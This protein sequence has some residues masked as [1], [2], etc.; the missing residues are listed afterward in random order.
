M[1][2]KIFLHLIFLSLCGFQLT[3]QEVNDSTQHVVEEKRFI[4][5]PDH[6]IYSDLR[7]G[8]TNLGH[9][10]HT[11]I[12]YKYRYNIFKIGYSH[13]N[14]FHQNKDDEN[15]I[16]DLSFLYGWSF[17]KKNFL[18]SASFGIGGIWGN[19]QT[20]KRDLDTIPID[21]NPQIQVKT[22]GFPLEVQFAF[23]PPPKLKT[24]SSIGLIFFGNFN[25]HKSYMGVGLN[26]AFG[27][28]SPKLTEQEKK[29]PLKDYYVPKE[30]KQK[31]YD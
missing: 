18:F 16:N 23:T 4:H 9:Q 30:R 13:T 24:F 3:A 29:N 20:N 25:N 10:L 1:K 11:G 2:I 14:N 8:Y 5:N 19:A 31:W 17:R 7:Y 28:V 15:K 22:V 27:K 12:S 21:F 6:F 26:L